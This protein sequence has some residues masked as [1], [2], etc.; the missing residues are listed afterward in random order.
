MF[1]ALCSGVTDQAAVVAANVGN[2][3]FIELVATGTNR[4]GVHNA[5]Q[6]DDSDFGGATA[7]VHNHGTA[8]FLHRQ[9]STNG[10]SHRLFNQE[11][12]PGTSAQG[13]F[14]DSL[15][16]YLGGFAG[17][18]N[19][20][21]GAWGDKAVLMH[22]VDEVLEHFLGNHEICDHTVFHRTDGGDVSR[23]AAKHAF[24]FGA[25][26]CDHFL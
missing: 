9:A 4:L 12:F 26:G 3:R 2:D 22:L 10:R 17:N 15:T 19:Q 5:I 8:G 6:G 11:H 1:D 20:Y 7:D 23:C 14:T 13:G 18:A 21:A 16:L 24:G 25:D